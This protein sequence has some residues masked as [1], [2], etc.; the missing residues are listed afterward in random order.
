MYW[1]LKSDF[2]TSLIFT[3]MFLVA[4]FDLVRKHFAE[5]NRGKIKS[6]LRKSR[7][8]FA[9]AAIDIESKKALGYFGYNFVIHLQTCRLELD[10]RENRF[11]EE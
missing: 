2:R 5:D 4:I 8:K 7:I 1:A 11:T 6:A 9:M 3:V 10:T